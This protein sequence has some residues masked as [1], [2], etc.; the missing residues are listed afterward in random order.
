MS[1]VLDKITEKAVN[2]LL[3]TFS[4]NTLKN[5]AKMTLDEKA[6]KLKEY[7]LKLGVNI[8]IDA[9]G[10]VV[11]DLE[12]KF[13]KGSQGYNKGD[14]YLHIDKSYVNQ[15]DNVTDVIT[16]ITHEARHQIQ[17]EAIDDPS[18]FPEIPLGTIAEWEDNMI[19][20]DDG[21]FGYESYYYQ[22]VEVDARVF[23]ADV[24]YEAL[25][26]LGL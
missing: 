15:P 18:K 12:S 13:G 10:V 16:T 23:G 19:N 25:K 20:Y 7:Y 26:R 6:K 3:S 22:V 9:K 14:G 8:G 2:A 5:W 24:V 21:S 4:L 1:K 11:E 17:S